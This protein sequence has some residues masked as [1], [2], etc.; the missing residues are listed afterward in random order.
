MEFEML[1]VVPAQR[2]PS[3]VRESPLADACGMVS[4]DK[5][6]LRHTRFEDVYALGDCTTTPNSKTAAAV[7]AQAPVVAANLL[8]ARE[9]RDPGARYD[10]Y[11]ACPLT[12]SYG[13]VMLAEFCYDGAVAPSFPLDPRVPRRAYWW[14]KKS[15][16]PRLYWGMLRG[17]LGL[18]WHR[19][20]SY[21]EPVPALAP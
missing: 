8:A 21:P 12:T 6:T 3:V 18:D 10:G 20:R 2:A 19:L 4:V 17:S 5:H 9:G 13:K 7:R 15:Y 1:H 14:L 16:M 11:A